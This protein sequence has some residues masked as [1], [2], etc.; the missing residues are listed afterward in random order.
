MDR[1]RS[2]SRA[3]STIAGLLEESARRRGD[4]PAL[5]G[6]G[7]PPLDFRGLHD[8]SLETRAALRAAGVGPGDRVAIAL[9]DGPALAAA[10]LATASSAVAAPLNPAYR[11]PEFEF[12]FEDLGARAVLLPPGPDGAAREAATALGIPVLRVAE[13]DGPAGAFRLEKEGRTGKGRRAK[14]G[15]AP[16]TGSPALVLH[17]S[18]TTARPKQ[19]PLSHGNL[20]A[21]ARV[22]A[23][24][25]G[26]GPGDR[27][28]AVMPLFHIH[29]LVGVLLSS[30]ASGGSVACSPG[31]RAPEFF[32]WTRE[33]RPT[34]T[35]AVPTMHQSILER[36]AIEG[37]VPGGTSLRFARSSSASLPTALQ[38]RL[39]EA[40][41]I[42]LLQAYGMTEASHQIACNPP[43]PGRRKPGSVGRATG[44]RIRVLGS[45]LRAAEPGIEGDVAVRGPGLTAGYAGNPEANAA[46]FTRGWFRTGDRGYL[47]GEGY[48]FLTGR[49]REIIN[50]GGEKI[51]PLEVDEALGSHP[52]VAQALAFAIPHPR[53]GEEVGAAV[54]LRPGAAV[55]ERQLRD[56]AAVRLA[57]HKVPG[58]VV[59]LDAIP[60]GPTGKLRRI[61]LASLLGVGPAAAPE[62]PVAL[63]PPSSETERRIADHLRGVLRVEAVGVTHRFETLG[64]DSLTSLSVANWIR[65]T[66]GSDFAA[67]ELFELGTV[68]AV[69]SR[70]DRGEGP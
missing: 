38:S 14:T 4:A 16:R 67:R 36:A 3:P 12:Y 20:L 69:A 29:G 34:W 10:F 28:L 56:Y 46:A 68:A 42:P 65:S 26:L 8:V 22:I 17:T 39:E 24:S 19:V 62:A 60:R 6:E 58:R 40:L 53:L 54:V 33:L 55:S 9:P 51:A 1:A 30:L 64:L 11:R 21:S 41:G 23:G 66:F 43:P 45:G 18:G 25:L 47:D 5:I 44:T 13:E 52:A 63:V 32:R 57:P 31:F 37:I 2:R 70:L 35:S 7:R 49:A 27:C 15:G 48:L 59:F 61:G 50:R